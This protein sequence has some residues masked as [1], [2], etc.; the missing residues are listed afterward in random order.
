[1]LLGAVLVIPADAWAQ[2]CATPGKDGGGTKTSVVN[3]YFQGNGNLVPTPAGTNTLTLG[4]VDTRF[5]QTPVTVGDLL[6]IIQ[7]QDG[8][9][10]STNTANYGDGT[11]VGSGSTSA[12][13]AGQYEFVAVTAISGGSGAG[14]VVTFAPNLTNTYTQ[15]NATATSGQKRYQVVRVPQL[16]TPTFSGVTAPPWGLGSASSTG[17]TGGIAVVDVSGA[18][19]LDGTAPTGT[20]EG[21]TNRSFFLG[22]KGF[23]GGAGTQ[24]STNASSADWAVP[25]GTFT[26]PVTFAGD[27]GKGEGIAGT[28]RL[29]A[30]K[31]NNWGFQSTNAPTATG[32]LVQIDQ[33]IEGYPTGSHARGA[34]ANAGGGGS[35]GN[36]TVTGNNNENAGGGGGGNYGP[37]G[38]GGRPWNAP[39]VDSA[40][41][42]GA[43]YGGASGVLAFNRVFLGGGGGSGSTNDGTSDAGTYTNQA[44]GC[45]LGAGIC[46]SGA[47]GGGIV[48][49]R[50]RSLAGSGII[51]LRGANAYNVANDAGG[52]GGAGGSV[53]IYSI[54]GGSATINASGGDGGNAWASKSQELG[55]GDT[56]GGAGTSGYGDRHGPGGGGGGGFIVFSPSSLALSPTYSGGAPGRTTNGPTDTYSSVTGSGGLS[57]FQTPN[58]PGALPGALCS[59]DL[60]L[61]KNDGVTSLTSGTSNTYTFVAT[62]LGS[63]VTSGTVTVVDPLPTG[64]TVADG[65]L[66]LS[67]AQSVNWTCTAASNVVTCTSTATAP[68]IAPNGGTSTFA[69]TVNVNGANGTAVTNAAAIGGGGDPN[70]PTPTSATAAACTGNDTPS[71]CAVDTDTILA[72]LLSLTKTDGST[73]VVA[74]ANSTYALT[75]TNNGTVATSG[76]I[77]VLDTLPTGMS[78]VAGTAFTSSGFSCTYTGASLTFTCTSTTP[79]AAGANV[80]ITLPAVAVAGTAP[81]ALTNLARVWGGNDPGKSTTPVPLASACPAPTPPATNSSDTSSG[82]AGDTDSVKH[83]TL[84]MT[85]DDGQP[86]IAINGQTTYVFTV[87]NSGDAASVGTINFRDVLPTPLN[88][89]ATLTK[90]GT[91]AGDWTCNRVDALNVTC[92][93]TVSIAAGSTSQFSL[94]ANAGAATS[95]NQYL[96]TSRISGGGDTTLLATAPAT[97]DVTACTGTN[98]PVGCA[99]D[100][101]T[102][103]TA[104]QIRLSKAHANPQAVSPGGTVAFTLTVSNSGGTSSGANTIRVIDVLPTGLTYSGAATF[105]SGIFT[106]AFATPNI[107]CNNTGGALAANSTAA[108][109]FSATVAAAATNRLVNPAQATTNGTDPQ[110]ATFGTA[111]TAGACTS[112]NVPSIGCA[113][114]P[115]PLNADLQIVKSQRAGTSGTFTTSALSVLTGQTVQF[116]LVATNAGPATVSNTAIS[117][118]VPSQFTGL[119]IVSAVGSSGVVGCTTANITLTGSTLGGTLTTVPSAG[120]CTIVVQATATTFGTAIANTATISVPS[121]ITDST[122]ANNSSTVNTTIATPNLSIVKAANTSG[123]IVTS[124]NVGQSSASYAL[125]IGNSGSNS[126]GT[127]SVSDTLPTGITPNWIGTLNYTDGAAHVWACSASGQTVTC[128]TGSVLANATTAQIVLPV[129]VTASTSTSATNQASI[130]G[131]G[132]P[133]NGGS[134]LPPNACTD[135]ATAPNHCTSVTTAIVPIVNLSI[136]KNDGLSNYVP[137]GTST[138]TLTISNTGPSAANGAALSDV[139]PKGMTLSAAWTCSPGA[140]CHGCTLSAGVCTGG[141]AGTGNGTV[142]ILSG[143]TVDVPASSSVTITVPVQFS[144][145]PASY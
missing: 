98:T 30:V 52:G 50:A 128:T 65:S 77:T 97:A 74:G 15:A 67:G 3:T 26:T 84:T 139:L 7:M 24:S 28:P 10:N 144:S 143:V 70:K 58:V 116:Q 29:Y 108:I 117:D 102:A 100:L 133:F 36:T 119:S 2:V 64:L 44:M 60:H 113:V 127:V 40:G 53:V 66:T 99:T 138:Y 57:T 72:P 32:N 123:A 83:V 12:G 80:V 86:Y 22:G 75:V 39:T 111:A 88:W 25:A 134:Q 43:G 104:A 141:T 81:S 59:S 16:T 37:G 69:F 142:D 131:G 46:S 42:G 1:M 13:S 51:D 6:L 91:N 115:L 62:N 71:G 107:T 122:P 9:L 126:V 92:S 61:S 145:N 130:G 140:Q 11:G 103:Q 124:W 82:C 68:G 8:T 33:G 5:A 89:P 93:S 105:T 112:A 55:G 21:Q 101:D 85:K 90:G 54:N 95:G 34:P 20:V 23:R 132:D 136:T 114:D 129:N 41:R 137:G 63:L 87:T 109:T 19:V 38:I 121:G 94:V 31:A 48:I 49:I 135:A 27:G 73:S 35:D 14:A 18:A 76:T 125:T 4:A 45:S 110:N 120:T 79:I 96:N 56:T 17:E 106:C 78:Y 47:A 118:P